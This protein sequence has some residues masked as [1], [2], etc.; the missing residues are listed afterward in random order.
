LPWLPEA[1][2]GR[3]LR[4]KPRYQRL[5]VW[6]LLVA[7]ALLPASARA[8][9]QDPRLEQAKSLFR[10]GN[11]LLA[12]GAPE[13]ALERFLASRRLVASG[14]N[15]A[16]AA[17]CLE[18]LGRSDE[19]LEMYEDLV[20]RFSADLDEQDRQNLA[21]IMAQLAARLG[22]LDI[23][24]NVEALVTVD[25]SPRGKL[26]RT[27]AMKVMPGKRRVRVMKEGY[28][29]FELTVN[30]R[31]GESTAIDAS[32]EPLSGLGAL[33]VEQGSPGDVQLV[34]D[35]QPLGKLPWEGTLGVGSHLLQA[36][37][38][39]LGSKPKTVQVVERKTQLIRLILRPLGATIQVVTG[40]PSATVLLDGEALGRG[41]WRGR[42]PLGSYMIRATEFGYLTSEAPLVVAA[43]A[44]AQN[45]Q[46]RLSR[47]PNSARW[48]KR[49]WLL[50]TVGVGGAVFYAPTL[51][52]GKE[53]LCPTS[54]QGSQAATG[55]RFEGTLE[56]M[57][58]LG[59]GAELGVGYVFAR[60]AFTR[61][62]SARDGSLNISYKLREQ[63]ALGGGHVR[64][65]AVTQ[66]RLFKDLMLRSALGLGV[67]AAAYEAQT[68]GSAA[69]RSGGR[70]DVAGAGYTR[71][72]EPLLLVTTGVRLERGFGPWRLSLG[73]DAWFVPRKGPKF[74]G[75]ELQAVSSCPRQGPQAPSAT[76]CV[77]S[78]GLISDERAHGR[79][80]ALLP[81]ATIRYRF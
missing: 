16:N 22:A 32:L 12:A 71:I 39:A 34:V 40:S 68:S 52:G 69:T 14:K 38:D 49:S 46:L 31:P 54:C 15:T 13:A 62:A 8:D 7:I 5:G 26:P 9:D 28:Q 81:E 30:V 18:R 77:P 65:A 70:S 76:A 27:S 51:K 75:A 45:L 23:S 47:D 48:P 79:F 43:G 78:S 3:A 4:S 19:A 50:Y 20:A 64:A 60:Q 61:E 24:A 25:G 55:G 2:Y 36:L 37:G 35:G 29:T 42:L 72:S 66:V 53:A 41:R 21:P 74:A 1:H 11:A 6:L 10:Q 80:A 59:I 57:H 56:I 73:L 17:I 58:E 33:R 44:E 67:V 63:L